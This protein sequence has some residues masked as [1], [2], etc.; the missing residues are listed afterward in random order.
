M[1]VQDFLREVEAIQDERPQYKLGHDGSD[2]YCDCIGLVI[3]AMRRN[4]LEWDGTK[5]H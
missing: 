4:G 2:G 3:G 1:T 5:R